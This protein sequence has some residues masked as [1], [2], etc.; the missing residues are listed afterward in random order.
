MSLTLSNA[1][2]NFQFTSCVNNRVHRS[3]FLDRTKRLF[4]PRATNFCKVNFE[5]N[6]F[7]WTDEKRAKNGAQCDKRKEKPTDHHAEAHSFDGKHSISC[8]AA[9]RKHIL[10][11]I[12]VWGGFSVSGGGTRLAT[13]MD[14]LCIFMCTHW[15]QSKIRQS[16][17]VFWA[18]RV[19][20]YEHLHTGYRVCGLRYYSG[21]I[22]HRKLNVHL[23][24]VSVCCGTTT[25]A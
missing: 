9:S 20:Q 23:Y 16:F 15:W 13:S 22:F 21:R 5:S 17:C 24:F 19:L 4:Q 11:C 18:H 8:I 12:R 6:I 10:Q 14:F 25:R 7:F 3:W 1:S 2:C